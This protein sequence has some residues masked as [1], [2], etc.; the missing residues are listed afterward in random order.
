MKR[1]SHKGIHSQRGFG[2]AEA[3]VAVAILSIAM[4]GFINFFGVFDM[5]HIREATSTQNILKARFLEKAIWLNYKAK[6][7]LQNPNSPL[8][9][10]ANC[11][12]NFSSITQLG[13]SENTVC[14]QDGA[15]QIKASIQPISNLGTCTAQ[16]S[17]NSDQVTITNCFGDFSLMGQVAEAINQIEDKERIDLLFSSAESM[18]ICQLDGNGS[19]AN[20]AGGLMQLKLKNNCILPAPS[21]IYLPKNLIV[22]SSNISPKSIYTK[23]YY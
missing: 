4:I 22:I 8:V 15:L 17:N 18:I 6:N 10:N 16:Q 20:L 2:L 12:V 3:L 23:I 14:T 9:F 19:P 13:F 1:P 5:G 11:D 7:G 21:T